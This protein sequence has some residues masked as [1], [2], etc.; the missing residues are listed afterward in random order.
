MKKQNL[1]TILKLA[2]D[3]VCV[4]YAR[5]FICTAIGDV[6]LSNS[7]YSSISQSSYVEHCKYLQVKIQQRLKGAIVAEQW[8][9]DR[10]SIIL[11][12]QE[13][14][15]W[16]GLWIDMLIAEIEEHGRLK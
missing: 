3:S 7:K 16:R 10:H 13:M 6:A 9:E 11:K 5:M 8:L 14:R 15:Q 1:I 2:K 12:P 4:Y